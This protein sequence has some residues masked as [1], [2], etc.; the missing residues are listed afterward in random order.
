MTKFVCT[1]S[2]VVIPRKV[3]DVVGGFPD[4]M[5]LGGDQFM[6]IKI[7]DRFKIC[8]SPE[9]LS[10]YYVAA[11][12]RSAA[13]YRK[14]ITPYSFEQLYR[15]GEFWMNEFIARVALGKALTISAKGGTEDADRAL[16]F[17]AYNRYS[18]RTWWKVRIINSLPVSWRWPLLRAY[19]RAAWAIAKKG[20]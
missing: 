14:E 20:M 3:F 5:A 8:F 4:G 19:N 7:A 9:P 6:W 18:R 10:R 17:F 12:N 13:I 11:S 1:A 16:K 2:S 15:K